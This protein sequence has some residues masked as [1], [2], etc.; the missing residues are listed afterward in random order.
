[1]A[2][3]LAKERFPDMTIQNRWLQLFGLICLIVGIAFCA[4]LGPDSAH[5]CLVVELTGGRAVISE[6]FDTAQRAY[7][8]A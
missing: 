7:D 5:L 8:K 1:M 3:A 2:W 4:A 6:Q